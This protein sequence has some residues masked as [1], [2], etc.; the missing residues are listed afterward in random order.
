LLGVPA[1]LLGDLTGP[2][3]EARRHFFF[4]L[5]G[6]AA[7][8]AMA[9]AY[10]LW[11]LRRGL[12]LRAALGWA[13]AGIVCLPSWYYGTS[14]FDDILGSAVVVWALVAAGPT[15]PRALAAGLLVG[16]AFNCKQPLAV[17]A[18]PV[19]AALDA[20]GQP[21]GTV[22]RRWLAAAG[23]MALGLLAYAAYEAY[24]FPPGHEAAHA[25]ELLRYFPNWPGKPLTNL[26]ALAISPSAGVLWYCPPVVLAAIGCWRR[27]GRLRGPLLAALAVFVL[28]IASMT[29]FKGDWAWGPRYLTPVF[30]LL[31]LFAPDGAAGLPRR[32]VAI[33]LAAGLL[34]Q[35]LALSVEPQRL[36]IQRDLPSAFGAMA[37]ILYFDTR[38]AHLVNRPRE[39]AEIWRLRGA[40][41]SE[42]TPAPSPTYTI[43]ILDNAPR[44]PGV[45]RRYRLLNAYRPWWA[46]QIYLPAEKRP[47]DIAWGLAVQGLLLAAGVCLI[48]RSLIASEPRTGPSARRS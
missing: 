1:I 37:P 28:F 34:V 23:G 2:R 10:L 16:L 7:A 3:A 12:G 6:A 32:A 11:L 30:A 44:G 31:W 18:L 24:K 42:Y 26:A 19:L 9:V 45:V 35:V 41:F 13:A 5:A 46:S 38:N 47:V 17:V 36:Y 29:I 8:A 43:P 4:S 21:R 33:L 39:I 20:P 14:T 48:L 15:G 22:A 25:V 40:D 27:A